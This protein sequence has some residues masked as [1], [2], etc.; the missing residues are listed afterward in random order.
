MTEFCEWLG[1]DASVREIDGGTLMKYRSH[2]LEKMRKT[3]W[4]RTTVRHYLVSVKS[5]VRWLWQMEAIT[6]L[7]RILVGKTDFLEVGSTPSNV[8]VFSTNEIH[9]LLKTASDRTRL[10]I[11]LML[12]CGMTQKDVSDLK[13]DEVDWEMGRINRKRS[14]TSN[15][16]TVPTVNYL[17]WP[18]TFHL[19]QQERSSES[20]DRLLLNSN[21]S[22]LCAESIDE[23]DKY[24]KTDNIKNAF[25]R[26]RK[27]VNIKKP[28]KSLKKTS[29]SLLR[30]DERFQGLDGLFLGHA[31]QSM[32]D[33]HYTL[34]PTKLLDRAITWLRRQY[35]IQSCVD[36]D[37]RDSIGSAS[38]PR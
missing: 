10:Y 18:E 3:N 14:K 12:N 37:Q 7:P 33:K 28:L 8:V 4:S 1:G 5:F 16:D 24:Q 29:A 26:L 21:G 17:L 2:L 23:D 35:D 27:K 22:P 20:A 31:P 38:K 36:D 32:S 25:D 6:T 15:H 34:A 9:S 11:L 30:G 13:V 19:L